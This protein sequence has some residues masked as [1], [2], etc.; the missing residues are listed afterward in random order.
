M[1]PA[2][3]TGIGGGIARACVVLDNTPIDASSVAGGTKLTAHGAPLDVRLRGGERAPAP[4]TTAPVAVT[5]LRTVGATTAILDATTPIWVSMAAP[6]AG[7]VP[8]V[9]TTLIR[10]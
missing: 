5:V 8:A 4:A 1:C 2:A 9:A 3:A 6:G 7:T 10:A